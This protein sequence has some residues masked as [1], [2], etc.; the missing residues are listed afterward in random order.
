MKKHVICEK[1]FALNVAQAQEMVAAAE[2]AG[3]ACGVA[4]EFRFVPQRAA[5]K[6]LVENHHLDPLRDIEITHLSQFLRAEGTRARGWWFEKDKG[7]GLA[8]ALLSHI[9][10]SA[11]WTVGRNPAA[12]DRPASH[13][14]PNTPR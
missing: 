14:E 1:P 3:T 2:R 7:G 9:I 4:H 8:G 6:Q 12:N 10:D 13:G 11:T 5:L